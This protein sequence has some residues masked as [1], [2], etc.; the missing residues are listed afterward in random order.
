MTDNPKAELAKALAAFQANLPKV[1]KSNLAV[2][3]SDKGS[4][5][6]TY[7]DL[8]D[9][10]A[11]A[12]PAL[13]QH[14]LSFNAV[15]TVDEHGQ[16]VLRCQLRHESGEMDE[17]EFLLP[18]QATP[19]QLGSYLTYF[20]RYGLCAMT[21]IVADEDD[22]GAAASNV[23]A[24]T[25]R[26]RPPADT[27]QQDNADA[28]RRDLAALADQ[29]GYPRPVVSAEYAARLKTPLGDEMD[30]KRIRTFLDQV[31]KDPAAVLGKKQAAA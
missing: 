25:Q 24:Q 19:Q 23:P 8:A 31:K 27:Q 10:S 3:K 29:L 22:D 15:P 28:A 21:G 30:P 1:G 9:I 16:F 11:V 12:L 26:Q 20:R 5:K 4:Y 7:A 13:A 18:K 2:V 17:G 14:G 6:Y